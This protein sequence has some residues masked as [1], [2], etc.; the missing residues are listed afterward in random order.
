MFDQALRQT[1]DRVMAPLI[2]LTPMIV[3]PGHITGFG[4]SVGLLACALASSPATATFAVYAWLANRVM[5]CMD[6][7]VARKR[8]MT[9]QLGGFCDLLCDFIVYSGIPVAVAYSQAPDARRAGSETGMWLSVAFL[10]STFHINNFVL[11]YC[12]AVIRREST[13][14]TSVAMKT[15]LVEGFESGIAFT[16]M[17]VWP[18]YITTFS[19]LLGVLVVIGIVQRSLAISAVLI[20]LDIME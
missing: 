14:L 3:T 16:A 4:F 20:K 2:E 5:D 9:S 6:G 18:H 19:W 8:N 13:E 7:G 10:E 17:L 11:F 12:A 1:K 15:A